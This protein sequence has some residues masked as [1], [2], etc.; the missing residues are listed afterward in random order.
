MNILSWNCRGLGHPLAI[1]TIRELVRVHKPS[2]IFLFETLA[3]KNKVE[4]IRSRINFKCCFVVDC[5][6]RS[7]GLCVLWKEATC[8]SILNFSNN[9]IDILINCSRGEWRLTGFYG[10]PE[11]NRRRQSWNLLR[12][13]S[14][15]S[16][17]PWVVIGDFNDLLNLSDKRGSVEHPN[18]LFWGF[19]EAGADCNLIGLP[20][21][22][23]PFTWSRGI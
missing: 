10:F 12:R 20:L 22:G 4:E 6:G 17:L 16:S 3:S 7:G 14:S 2:V 1:S 8:F 18:W 13:L 15:S 21:T 9:H 19:R 11:R 23:Y 5:V